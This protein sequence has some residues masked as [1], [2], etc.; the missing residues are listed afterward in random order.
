MRRLKYLSSAR[1]DLIEIHVHITHVS[2]SADVGRNFVRKIQKK[3]AGLARLPGMMGRPRPELLAEIRSFA[4]E[5]YIIF[6]RY[7]DDAFEVV[8]V[9]E[10]HRDVEDYFRHGIQARD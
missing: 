5:S 3:C 6:F 1:S 8:N 7:I 4:F 10:G 9:L 2:G